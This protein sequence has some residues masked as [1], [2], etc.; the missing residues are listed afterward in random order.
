MAFPVVTPSYF[1]EFVD[2]SAP[3]EEYGKF[4]SIIVSP[5][6]I[7]YVLHLSN[8]DV[9]RKLISTEGNL[10]FNMGH[11]AEDKEAQFVE[12]SRKAVEAVPS[13]AYYWQVRTLMMNVLQNKGV[14]FEKRVLLLNYALKTI[15]GMID[16]HQP[17]EIPRFIAKFIE[18]TEIERILQYFNGIAP[19]FAYSLTD[20]ISFLKAIPKVTPAYKE[21]IARIY[22]NLGVSGPE[23]LKQVDMKHYIE[24]R[25]NFTVKF[26]EEHSNWVE[27]VMIN[28]VWAYSIPY[29]WTGRLNIWENY[30]FFCTLYN[31]IKLLITCYVPEDEDDF[32]KMISSFDDALRRAGMD[33]VWKTVTA[34]KNAGQSNNGDMA[35]LTVS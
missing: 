25:R 26:M 34:T 21:V 23:T 22:K 13:A 9:A 28:Y 10:E 14:T 33:F 8:P 1:K 17:N 6:A 7:E 15:Q 12:Q 35:I 3:V 27:K 4:T 30:V 5:A 18:N 32:I 11:V 31:A 2:L 19:N 24:L 20:G 16:N 29:S